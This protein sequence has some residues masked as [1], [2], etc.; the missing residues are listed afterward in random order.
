MAPS[1]TPLYTIADSFDELRQTARQAPK[2]P[3]TLRQ[4]GAQFESLFVQLV[5][6]NMREASQGEGLLSSQQVQFYQGLFDQQI[7]LE[8]ARKGGLGLA[9][10]IVSQLGNKIPGKESLSSVQKTAIARTPIERV[11]VTEKT[12]PVLATPAEFAQTL[13]PYAQEAAHALQVDPRVLLAQAALETG[14][15]RQILRTEA[16]ESSY[17]LFNIKAD[18][19]WQGPVT[20]I[21]T[22]E[23]REGIAVREQARF[24]VYTSFRESF[25]DYVTFLQQQPR[26]HH[27][28][29]HTRS[30]E[31]FIRALAEAG[32]ATDPAYADKVLGVLRSETLGQALREAR[33][34]LKE[35]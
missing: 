10:M 32:Y 35:I 11:T 6:K 7:S 27:A 14:W 9:D 24:R 25:E 18:G 21:G 30:P 16:Q 3:E 17:N 12:A 28:L 5:L 33:M 31:S 15:G 8:L 26:Y 13:W 19:Q 2:D 1:T 34:T 23:Y 4:I 29:S 22:I 20:Q